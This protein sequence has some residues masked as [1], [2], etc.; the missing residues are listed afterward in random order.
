MAERLVKPATQPPVLGGWQIVSPGRRY[1]GALCRCEARGV[2]PECSCPEEVVWR[3]QTT[4][5]WSAS[6]PRASEGG[7]AGTEDRARQ[8][9]QEAYARLN[10]R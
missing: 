9:A 6:G 7:T 1:V 8:M 3:E 5:I 2:R 4:W 10:P